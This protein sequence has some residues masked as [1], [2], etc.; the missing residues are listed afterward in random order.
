MRI[1]KLALTIGI[2][3]AIMIGAAM[4]TAND[5][6]EYSFAGEPQI[7]LAVDYHRD[8]GNVRRSPAMRI[9]LR[10]ELPWLPDKLEALFKRLGN[11]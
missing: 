7:V 10:Q 8:S 6:Q 4:V 1:G 9:I 2:F 3:G 11:V 5:M